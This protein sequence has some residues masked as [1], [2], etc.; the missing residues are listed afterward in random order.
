MKWNTINTLEH[1]NNIKADSNDQFVLIFKN[2]LNCNVS[3]D[4]LDLIEENWKAG[5]ELRMKPYLVDVIKNRPL[6]MQIAEDYNIKH[7]SPQVLLIRNGVCVYSKTHWNISYDELLD[8]IKA[9]N[10]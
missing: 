1:L 3:A 4:A 6:S 5:D 10:E 7:Q 2:S 9:D 8:T